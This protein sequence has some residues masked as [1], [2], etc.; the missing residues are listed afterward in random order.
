M[1]LN[2]PYTKMELMLACI[3]AMPKVEEHAIELEG[4]LNQ[5][6]DIDKVSINEAVAMQNGISMLDLINSPNMAYLVEQYK[7]DRMH[8]A[9]KIFVEF[10]LTEKEAWACLLSDKLEDL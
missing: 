5:L 10:G 6:H 1:V 9:V 7:S 3:T 2:L 4:R 8:E